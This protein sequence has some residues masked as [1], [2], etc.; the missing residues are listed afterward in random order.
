MPLFS[1]IARQK[2]M[3]FSYANAHGTSSF[4][5]DF[6]VSMVNMRRIGVLTGIEGEVR[7]VCTKVN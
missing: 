6:G 7:K 4:F 3:S 2:L 5:K 1:T